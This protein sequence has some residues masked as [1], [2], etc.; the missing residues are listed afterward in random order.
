MKNKD[1]S[2][3]STKIP[4]QPEIQQKRAQNMVRKKNE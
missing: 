1:E 2:T 4:N 3:I